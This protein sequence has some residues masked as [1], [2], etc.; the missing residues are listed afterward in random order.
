MHNKP[1]FFIFLTQRSPM[2][3][4]LLF[5]LLIACSTQQSSAITYDPTR[6]LIAV[7]A[8][9][10]AGWLFGETLLDCG[11]RYIDC[12]KIALEYAEDL[13]EYDDEHILTEQEISF[14]AV[15]QGISAVPKQYWRELMA[16]GCTLALICVGMQQLKSRA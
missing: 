15:I 2:K 5:L 10:T 11:N 3:K 13:K 9:V 16:T 8:F 1:I 6:L 4:F 12:K 14:W 7:S